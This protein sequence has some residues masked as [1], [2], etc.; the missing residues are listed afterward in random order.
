[1]INSR[2][3]FSQK[4]SVHFYGMQDAFMKHQRI[5][6]MKLKRVSQLTLGLFCRCREAR[7]CGYV[8]TTS[9]SS[10]LKNY[11]GNVW[12][13]TQT[14]YTGPRDHHIRDPSKYQQSHEQILQYTIK[15]ASYLCSTNYCVRYRAALGHLQE[16][17]LATSHVGFRTVKQ[18]YK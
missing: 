3:F 18:I 1:M 10:Q 16:L 17:D 15:D 13:W 9:I 2:V 7:R 14:S 6:V 11:N 8:C 12:E 5:I 4:S